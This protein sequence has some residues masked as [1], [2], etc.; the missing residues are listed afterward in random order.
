MKKIKLVLLF[1]AIASN[2]L[3]SQEVIYTHGA[4]ILKFTK[5]GNNYKTYF[6]SKI[7]NEL[8]IF[9]IDKEFIK[10]N[11]SDL[12]NRDTVY[13]IIENCGE[14]K[15][16]EDI[17]RWYICHDIDGITCWIYISTEF[18]KNEEPTIEIQ[19]ANSS[20]VYYVVK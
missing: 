18:V 10:I 6:N 4:Q 9:T 3:F 11:C 17:S 7:F 16:S 2:D 14:I 8:D 19:Y 20:I 1:V 13:K 5:N 15:T 12:K